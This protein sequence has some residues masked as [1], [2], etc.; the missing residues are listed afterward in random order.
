MGLQLIDGG[1][2]HGRARGR[3][4]KTEAPRGPDQPA[5]RQTSEDHLPI[6]DLRAAMMTSYSS[7]VIGA[8]PFTSPA[9]TP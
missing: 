1:H 7:W 4:L 9:I 8:R 5:R 3:R 2:G 6:F